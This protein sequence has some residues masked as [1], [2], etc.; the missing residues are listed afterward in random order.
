MNQIVGNV[1]FFGL[2][3][4]VGYLVWVIVSPF[5]A[6]LAL[7]A[8]IVT[9]TYPIYERIV[10][11]MPHQNTTLAALTT[12]LLALVVVILPFTLIT[13]ALVSEAVAIYR[14]VGSGQQFG[15]EAAVSEVEASIQVYAPAFELDAV[16]FL[17]QGAE[18]LTGNLTAIFTGTVSTIFLFFLSLVASFYFFRD[19][20]DFTRKLVRLSPLP[21]GEDELILSRLAQAIRSVA[22]GTVL[23][24]LIQGTLTA[25]G[26]AMFGF[27][28]AV[29]WGSIAALGALIPSVGTSII[30]IP[31]V[32]YLL[33]T[34]NV[35]AAI[36]LSIWGILAVGLIDNLLGP[37]LMSRGNAQHPFVILLAVLGGISL[38]GPIGFIAG[39][40]IISFFTVLVELYTTHLS[41]HQRHA[42]QGTH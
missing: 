25:V 3:G 37:Y 8:I 39:P 41:Q 24:A 12:T 40:V 1:F 14:V 23:V 33:F 28:R 26:L 7:A 42:D 11:R 27:E 22:T 16:E 5:M 6:A 38:F 15:F 9:I 31:A 18:W 21:D 30:F 36:G 2:L 19:G 10:P 32:G 13:S 20:K 34:G 35:P 29:L 4:I 17:R